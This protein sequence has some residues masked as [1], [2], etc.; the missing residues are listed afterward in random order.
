MKAMDN[1]YL[2][3]GNF[4]LERETLRID[5]NGCLATTPHPFRNNKNLERDFC[6]NQLEIITPVCGSI[7]ELMTSLTKLDVYA[8]KVIA[9][10]G[11]YL[12]INSNPPH[13]DSEDEI[14]IA[15]YDGAMSFKYDYRL[16]LQ[17]RYGKRLMLLSGIHFNFSFVDE[18]LKSMYNGDNF[19]EFKNNMYFRL[20]KQVFRYSWLLVLLS[21]ASPVYDLSLLD[22]NNKSDKYASLRNSVKGY[23]NQFV[24]ILDYTDLNSYVSS[25]N[26]YIEKGALF[27][28]GELYLPVRL[29]AHSGS[30]LDSILYEGINHI[31]LRMFDLNPLSPIGIFREDLDFAHYLML[32]LIN[33]PDFEFTEE[34]QEA[35]VKNHQSAA[36]YDLSEIKINGYNAADAAIGLLDDMQEYFKQYDNVLANI[37][38]QKN[39]ITNNERYCVKINKLLSDNFQNVML[40]ISK[41]GCML[42]V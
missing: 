10:D 16:K 3:K 41:N 32:Y 22:G 8:R 42:D 34:L 2:F 7:E 25:V 17:R 12:W 38:F 6:E 23:W 19:D 28:A 4:G 26:R 14:C 40:D 13:F 36:L 31:E 11:E 39:K 1:N 24:P 30:G 21:A 9:K 20:S 15:S 33:L 29:K 37:K 18:F 35:A 27:S 5:S